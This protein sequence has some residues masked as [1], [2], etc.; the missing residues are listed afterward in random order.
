VCLYTFINRI[1]WF[2]VID[3][4]EVQTCLKRSKLPC[5]LA[6]SL[7][8]ASATSSCIARSCDHFCTQGL[9]I[10]TTNSVAHLRHSCLIPVIQHPDSKLQ[11]PLLELS[12]AFPLPKHFPGVPVLCEALAHIRTMRRS[13]GLILALPLALHHR[14]HEACGSLGGA[15][16]VPAP[17]PNTRRPLSRP[18]SASLCRSAH[19]MMEREHGHGPKPAGE[20]WSKD[21]RV[22]GGAHGEPL[23]VRT[24]LQPATRIYEDHRAPG[25]RTSADAIPVTVENKQSFFNFTSAVMTQKNCPTS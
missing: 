22:Q 25:T 16:W 1:H 18:P 17:P 10:N 2:K 14:T 23:P 8:H 5:S 4:L 21:P 24:D 6:G 9:V 20:H 13:P 3:V 12:S 15:I 19:T 7:A 11:Q